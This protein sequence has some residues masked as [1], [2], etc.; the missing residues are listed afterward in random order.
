[1]NGGGV[2]SRN[3]LLK[4]LEEKGY[5]DRV[6]EDDIASYA[7]NEINRLGLDSTPES[8][9][10]VIREI[11]DM[12]TGYGPVTRFLR[13]SE[14]SDIFINGVNGPHYIEKNGVIEETEIPIDDEAHLF[15]IIRSLLRYSGKSVDYAHPYADATLPDG[16]RIHVIIRPVAIH[17][18]AISIR[19]FRFRGIQL[20]RFIDLGTIDEHVYHLIKNFILSRKTIVISGG[21]G[22]G[23]TTMLNACLDVIPSSERLVVIED[24]EEISARHPH[25]IRL[26]T[27]HSGMDEINVTASTLVRQSLRMRPDRI[28]IGEIRG[29]ESFDF[30]QAAMTGHEGSMTTVHAGSAK[31]ATYRIEILSAMSNVDIPPERFRN[32]AFMAI[33]VIIQIIRDGNRRLVQS[34]HAIENEDLTCVWER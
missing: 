32:L 13:D 23:K 18:A 3:I 1:M 12:L 14:V 20:E 10:R 4:L 30:V 31:E 6:S 27:R 26:L 33:D 16:S 9:S 8:L 17:T 11:I 22:T 15:Q 19:R 24:T 25:M 34:I 7:F 21:T 29:P 2:I 5:P 28:I